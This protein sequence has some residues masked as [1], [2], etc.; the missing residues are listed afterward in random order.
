MDK[1]GPQFPLLHETP[2]FRAKIDDFYLSGLR[3]DERSVRALSLRSESHQPNSFNAGFH[4][5]I[6][7]LFGLTS[8]NN[9]ARLEEFKN[10]PVINVTWFGAEAYCRVGRLAFADGN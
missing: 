8:R 1:A 10:H 6:A 3:R 2:Q 5:S 9:I 4:G 7:S